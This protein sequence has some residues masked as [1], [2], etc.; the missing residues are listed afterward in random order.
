MRSILGRD[1]QAH[2]TNPGGRANELHQLSVAYPILVSFALLCIGAIL[3]IGDI[4]LLELAEAFLHKALGFVL[5]L[6]YLWALGRLAGEEMFIGASGTA[7]IFI[8]G[9]G[10]Q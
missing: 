6:T 4:L 9:F 5:V 2:T 10:L 1:Q 8:V 3:R 7:L